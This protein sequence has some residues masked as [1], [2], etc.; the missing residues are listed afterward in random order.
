MGSERARLVVDPQ[1]RP[2]YTVT[3][4]VDARTALTR[5]LSEYLAQLSIV[6]AGGR[7]L[8]FGR[9]FDTWADPEDKPPSFPS[10]VV[11]TSSPGSFDASQFAPAPLLSIDR[12]EWLFKSA[13]MTQELKVECWSTDT[14]ER[15]A[16][17]AM[18]QDGLVPV[19]WMYGCRVSLPFYHGAIATFELKSFNYVDSVDEALKRTSRLDVV[20]S[21]SVE[22][23]RR[24]THALAQPRLDVSD[25]GTVEDLGV[26][27]EVAGADIP[28]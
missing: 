20:V 16:V 22:V 2:I 4:E 25:V 23:I 5:G 24:R 18:L 21:G 6:G 9:V 13:E 19:D 3:R 14:K 15:V 12:S 10:A 8:R 11:Y 26:L 1:E 17:A 28:G 27:D 7:Q